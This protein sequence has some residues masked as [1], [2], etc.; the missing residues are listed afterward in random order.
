MMVHKL[1]KG[2]KHVIKDRKR[3]YKYE[4]EFLK[5]KKGSWV[6][7]EL[8]V[9]EWDERWTERALVMAGSEY[10]VALRE[11][12]VAEVGWSEISLI[13]V[14][15]LICTPRALDCQGVS[16]KVLSEHEAMLEML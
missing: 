14:G 7:L 16:C 4:E 6:L 11:F 13:D 1:G 9:D 10:N 8:K 12:M 2:V 5:I 15:Q 3:I